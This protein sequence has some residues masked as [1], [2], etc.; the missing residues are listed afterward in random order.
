MK[1]F[2]LG[3][4]FIFHCSHKVF[5]SFTHLICHWFCPDQ[6]MVLLFS[7]YQILSKNGE[8]F[9]VILK[10]SSLDDE[11]NFFP[12]SWIIPVKANHAQRFICSLLYFASLGSHEGNTTMIVF[13]LFFSFRF[14]ILIFFWSFQSFL[15]L[16][17]LDSSGSVDETAEVVS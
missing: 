17:L 11:H 1:E 15:T 13:H 8:L 12:M 2:N 9:V 3:L 4:E 7:V 14:H 10:I 5:Q 16:H 6:I